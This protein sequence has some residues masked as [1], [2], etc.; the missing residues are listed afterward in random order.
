MPLDSNIIFEQKCIHYQNVMDT[1]KK[2]LRLR[3]IYFYIS[4]S[5]SLFFLLPNEIHNQVISFIIKNNTGINDSSNFLPW[6]WLFVI[7]LPIKYFQNQ[8]NL[9]KEYD[10]IHKLEDELV[11]LVGNNTIFFTKEGKHYLNVYTGFKKTLHF[12][13]QYITLFILFIC[14]V[15]KLWETYCLVNKFIWLSH[16]L[17]VLLLSWL[18]I[19]YFIALK[20]IKKSYSNNP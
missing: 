4:L 2:S 1:H 5:F 14:P 16:L 18:I 9:E 8:I 20:E 13:Y 6:L 17:C 3:D 19:S 12:F 15:V 10:Y 7:I 11:N